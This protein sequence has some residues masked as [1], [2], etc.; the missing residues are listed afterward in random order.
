MA[1]TPLTEMRRIC[2]ALPETTE[3]PTWGEPHFR[4]RGKIFAGCGNHGGVVTIGF[5]L[6]REHADQAVRDPRFARA[7]YVGQHGWISM[8]AKGVRDWNEVRA[9]VL[10]SYRLIAPK[11]LWAEVQGEKAVTAKSKTPAQSK[12]RSGTSRR[13]KSSA[14]KRKRSAATRR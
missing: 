7:P 3:T 9:L 1:S 11:A 5:K 6:E 14:E 2:L 8:D 13:G 4:V 10:E 12:T